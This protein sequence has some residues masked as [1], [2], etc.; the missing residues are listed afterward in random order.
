[1]D[2][3]ARSQA[4]QGDQKIIFMK[5]LFTEEVSNRLLVQLS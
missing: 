5:R 1:M 4:M 3:E 2:F